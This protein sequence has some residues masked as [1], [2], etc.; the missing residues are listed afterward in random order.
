[1]TV[2]SGAV[3]E[4]G[5]FCT[6]GRQLYDVFGATIDDH[7]FAHIAF[8]QD[9]PSLGGTGTSSGYAVQTDGTTIG[10]PND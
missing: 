1:M 6:S 9:S 2:H 8:S 10:S 3:C 5:V 4:N 7:G